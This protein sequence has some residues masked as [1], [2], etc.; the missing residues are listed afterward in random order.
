MSQA[1]LIQTT[2]ILSLFK[3]KW[4]LYK[5]VYKYLVYNEKQNKLKFWVYFS[6]ESVLTCE[7]SNSGKLRL[8]FL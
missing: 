2:T 3:K 5:Y 4:Y 8:K 1:P 7:C 6:I